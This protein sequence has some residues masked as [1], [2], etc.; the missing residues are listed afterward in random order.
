MPSVE[1][2]RTVR[3]RQ[4]AR[5]PSPIA[6]NV[7]TFYRV[8]LPP[9]RTTGSVAGHLCAAGGMANAF[10]NVLSCSFCTVHGHW[11]KPVGMGEQRP[12]P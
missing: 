1:K 2:P 10:S 7:A 4:D 5:S 9:A 12:P 3:V 11:S 6:R 8:G